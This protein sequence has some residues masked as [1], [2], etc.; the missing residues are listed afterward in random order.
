MSK[1]LDEFDESSKLTASVEV[2][3]RD[4]EDIVN[5]NSNS[6]FVQA[7]LFM[8]IFSIVIMASLVSLIVIN[9]GI[10]RVVK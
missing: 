7:I 3:K 10:L 8:V 1:K 2:K 9:H 5:Q 6:Y 4:T